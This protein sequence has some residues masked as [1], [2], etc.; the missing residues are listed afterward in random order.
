MKLHDKSLKT[1]LVGLLIGAG[2]AAAPYTGLVG[3]GP[4][5]LFAG[6]TDVC[7]VVLSEGYDTTATAF[8]NGLKRKAPDWTVFTSTESE[9]CEPNA[10]A[11]LVMRD[12]EFTDRDLNNVY[13]TQGVVGA[14]ALFVPGHSKHPSIMAAVDGNGEELLDTML[15]KTVDEV[16]THGVG[17]REDYDVPGEDGK[18]CIA[19]A[20]AHDSARDSIAQSI[21]WARPKWYIRDFNNA[22]NCEPDYYFTFSQIPIKGFGTEGYLTSVAVRKPNSPNPLLSIGWTRDQNGSINRALNALLPHVK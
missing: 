22:E 12:V 3:S 19:I 15:Q 8:A 1:C 9:P 17:G 14:I 16:K 2:L 18:T 13:R 21:S 6:S 10:Y 4:S 5:G 20:A 7:M 11:N